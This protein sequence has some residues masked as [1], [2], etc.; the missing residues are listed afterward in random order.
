LPDAG[1]VVCACLKVGAKTIAAAVA[2]GAE[3]LDAVAAVTAAGT[4]CG[5]CR[6][7]IARLITARAKEHIPDAATA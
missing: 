1:P 2:A 5:S 7:E 4:N 6:P 3:T